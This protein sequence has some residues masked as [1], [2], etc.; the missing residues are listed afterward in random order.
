[1][2]TLE[3]KKILVE[4][5][6]EVGARIARFVHKASGY[7]YLWRNEN[8]PLRLEAPGTE[9]DPNFY[10]GIDELLPNDLEET[11]DGIRCLDHGEL[12]TAE[13]EYSATPKKVVLKAMLARSGLEV[14]K[15]IWVEGNE[16]YVSTQ[17]INRS[18]TVK[19]F[20]WKLHAAVKIQP[21]DRI[22]CGAKQYTAVDPEWS[23]R[24]GEGPWEGETV[25]EF[26]NS[27]EFLYLHPIRKGLMEWTNG[28][29]TFQIK[30]DRD[31][32]RY[33]WYF[34]SYGG[35]YGHHVAVLEPCTCMPK[36]VNVASQ[37]GQCSVLK[38]GKSLF[39]VYRYVAL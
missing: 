18:D 5:A 14:G 8:L 35:F 30:F 24:G 17:I 10:G 28:E 22:T 39:S 21:G 12:W 31:V 1:M 15:L 4:I 6:P 29:R 36:E 20:L 33:C 3:N 9:Y 25:P 7:D 23:R 2:V 32:F 34:A 26:D 13:F 19:R 27:T 38:P 16:C 37:L 11:I